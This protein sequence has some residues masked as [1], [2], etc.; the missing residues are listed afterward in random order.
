MIEGEK[1][2]LD[3]VEEKHLPQL[4]EWRNDPENRK[5]YREYRVLTIEDKKK[6]YNDK[7]LNDNSWQFFVVKPRENK[8]KIIGT[9]GLTYINFLYRTAEFSITLGDREYRG[10]GYGSD[11]LKTIM[12][13]GFNDL[14]LNRI[15]CEV[16]SNNAAIE[17]Y[18]KV[19]FVKEGTL[20]QNVF[21]DGEYLDSTILSILKDEYYQKYP[22]K[23]S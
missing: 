22:R 9:V 21:K 11:M 7:I 16:Y 3:C 6:W 4:L 12:K 14:N 18:E 5:F 13:Y 1:I 17:I 23:L 19:G 8:D 2:I 15:W 10:K 20:R